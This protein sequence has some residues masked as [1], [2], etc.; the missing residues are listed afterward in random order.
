[1]DWCVLFIAE[2]MPDFN[3]DLGLATTRVEFY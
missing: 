2:N 1:M 3:L